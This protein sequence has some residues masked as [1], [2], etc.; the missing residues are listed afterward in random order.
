MCLKIRCYGESEKICLGTKQGSP[1]PDSDSPPLHLI[2]SVVFRFNNNNNGFK[3][4]LN[5]RMFFFYIYGEKLNARWVRYTDPQRI[6]TTP[7]DF[8][9]L[10]K[11]YQYFVAYLKEDNNLDFFFV[12][13][14][15]W[16]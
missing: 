5:A 13:Q 15:D 9:P 6:D 12:W 3:T 2:S 7:P 4:P 1:R 11:P 10:L 14:N 16:R 8:S